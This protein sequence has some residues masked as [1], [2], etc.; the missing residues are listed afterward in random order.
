[1]TAILYR[2]RAELQ[3][4]RAAWAGLVLLVAVAG[5][6]VL[7]IATGA[8]RTAT[9]HQRFV[10]ANHPAD[11]IVFDDG[12]VPGNHPDVE[13]IAH[14]PMVRES[15]RVVIDYITL[16]QS[17]VAYVAGEDSRAGTSIG[18]LQ[19]TSGRRPDPDRADEAAVSF[20]AADTYGIELGDRI[21][22]LDPDDPTTPAVAE[23]YGQAVAGLTFQVV[24]TYATPG[25]LPPV[26]MGAAAMRMTPAFYR[27]AHDLF[28][29]STSDS[30]A[31]RLR[32]GG[33]DLPAFRREAGKLGALFVVGADEDGRSRRTFDVQAQALRLLAAVGAVVVALVTGQVL[34]RQTFLESLDFA[35]LRALG[36][37]RRDLLALGVAR[38]AV[39]GG[40]G[41]LLAGVA[42]VLASPITPLGL[43]R[44]IEPSPGLWVDTA[45]LL[46][47]MGA[48]A[49]TVVAA[50]LVPAW[51]AADAASG[52]SAPEGIRRKPARLARWMAGG[53]LPPPAVVGAR[54]ALEPGR[55]RTATPVRTTVVAATV[56]IASLAAA[57]T[58]GTSLDRLLADRRLYG[59]SWDAFITNYGERG[60]NYR[61]T[62]EDL[63]AADGRISGYAVGT[64]LP[65]NLDG[66]QYGSLALDGHGESPLPP[67]LRGRAP[68]HPD[69][70]ALGTRT[71]RRHGLGVGDVIAVSGPGGDRP[72]DLRIVGV[73]VMPST[74]ATELGEGMLVTYQA[75]RRLAGSGITASDVLLRFAPGTSR[76]TR[77]EILAGLESSFAAR[78]AITE[79]SMP[80]GP[81]PAP[82]ALQPVEQPDDIVNFGQVRQLPFLMAGLL[83]LVGAATLLH[84]LASSVRR[85]RRDFAVLRMIGFT[86]RQVRATVAWQVATLVALMLVVGIPLGVSAGHAG[87]DLFASRAGVIPRAVTR[88]TAIAALVVATGVVAAAVAAVPARQAA[89]TRPATGL[90]WEENP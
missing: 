42:S 18:H 62:V 53:G 77:R 74:F 73:A 2:L 9:V 54:L 61:G 43:A 47:G 33:A 31:V 22:L 37:Q 51:R 60:A 6:G 16:G 45:A 90:R 30:L 21:P 88:E 46:V 65:L 17:D 66:R 27:L 85:R 26:V 83:A 34:A 50:S 19:I 48:I 72:V 68:I 23:R 14:L 70:V 29:D 55:G 87:W 57:L 4:R 5:G 13:A 15:V 79:P 84:L 12:A 64:D 80:G 59:V 56:A 76:A 81:V 35:N 11:A 82:F 7:T 36:L 10:A 71:I 67:I 44:T 69:E 38:A 78:V 1:M 89:R 86:G 58:F 28:D 40:A 75:V 41:A 3:S 39:A 8:R 32:R 24:G 49:A 63:L 20:A 52:L 25:E